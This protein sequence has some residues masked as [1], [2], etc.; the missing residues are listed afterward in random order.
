MRNLIGVSSSSRSRNLE[1]AP[2]VVVGGAGGAVRTSS[3][4]S[5]FRTFQPLTRSSW[6]DTTHVFVARDVD[7]TSLGILERT[8]G[9][10]DVS[11]CARAPCRLLA[12]M[13]RA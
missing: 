10:S 3:S 8:L 7:A 6:Y 13:R 4:L 11:R 12:H 5:V 9:I 1:D 2:V